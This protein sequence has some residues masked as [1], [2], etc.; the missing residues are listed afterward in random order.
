MRFGFETVES[1]IFLIVEVSIL[2]AVLWEAVISWHT[3][4][5]IKRQTDHTLNKYKRYK[6]KSIKDKIKEL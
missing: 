2:I 5:D 4:K 3:C 6:D 1:W